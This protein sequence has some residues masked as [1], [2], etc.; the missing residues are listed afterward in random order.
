M[1]KVV[2]LLSSVFVFACGDNAKNTAGE[3]VD[4]NINSAEHVEEN[5]HENRSPQLSEDP[6]PDNRFEV[7]TI[8]SAE[9]AKE[10]SQKSSE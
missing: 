7:D 10:Q 4:G 5:T 1:K 9:S 2:L 8:S 3:E 6:G